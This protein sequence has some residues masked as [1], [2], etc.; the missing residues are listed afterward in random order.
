M[1]GHFGLVVPPHTVRF[2]EKGQHCTDPQNGDILLVDHGSI[3]STLIEDAEKLATLREP[4]L[5]GY[6]WC[7]HA[8]IIRTDLG[9]TPVVSEMGF[10]GH[11][12]RPFIDYKERLGAVVNL[13]SGVAQRLAASAFDDAMAGAKYGWFE[14]PTIVLDDAT[15]L[16]LDSA[17]ADHVICSTHVMMVEAALGFMGDRLPV[18]VEPMRIAMWL[19][20][21]H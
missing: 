8:G 16:E 9:P 7:G 14:Y 15:G 6:T 1:S 13:Q 10:A 11:E 12:Y 19:G 4:A 3:A 2:Y 17:Y 21:A 18:R 5:R 20:A